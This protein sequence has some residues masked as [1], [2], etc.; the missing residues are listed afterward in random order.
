MPSISR[1]SM[2]P[3]RSRRWKGP[4]CRWWCRSRPACRSIR[5]LPSRRGFSSAAAACSMRCAAARGAPFQPAADRRRLD[6]GNSCKPELWIARGE[7]DT[8]S[9][10][11][12]RAR[13]TA[14]ALA[15]VTIAFRLAGRRRYRGG[16]ARLA[17]VADGEFVAIVGPTGCG[18]STL[19]NV[20]AGLIAPSAGPGRHFRRAAFRPQPAGGLSVSGGGA[21]SL[22]D[23]A[24]KR[25]DRPRN[26][27]HAAPR[28]ARPRTGM[29]DARRPAG[30]G[31]RYPQCSRAASG[32]ASA[33]PRC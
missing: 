13:N 7:R 8:G 27:R 33:S 28:G 29:A 25:R 32:S 2:S 22:E 23:R 30:F 6:Q 19:L 17:R 1:R 4:I 3:R 10:Q 14:V 20:A 12:G 16:R 15:D 24:R 26:R 11:C 31:Q 5:P 18:K 21:V 9:A